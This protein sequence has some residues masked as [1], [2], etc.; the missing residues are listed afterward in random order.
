MEHQTLLLNGGGWSDGFHDQAAEP[1]VQVRTP[2]F[3]H[4]GKGQISAVRRVGQHPQIGDIERGQ[5]HLHLGNLLRK[6]RVVHQRTAVLGLLHASDGLEPVQLFTGSADLGDAKA[7]V[8]EQELGVVPA[9]VLLTH[10]VLSRNADVVEEDLV[11]L[12]IVVEQHNRLHFDPGC[13]HVEQ[14]EG[15]PLLR[16]TLAVGAGE[17][18]HLVRVLG[19]GGPG[20]LTIE[21]PFVAIAHGRGLERRQIGA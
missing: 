3:Q 17:D 2:D 13:V 12:V 20:L 4:P 21:H 19:V 5:V 14:H 11:H 1:L 16:L 7:L 8:R 10:E 6:Q 15:N 9:L 18:E